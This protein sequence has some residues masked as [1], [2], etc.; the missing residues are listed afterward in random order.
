MKETTYTISEFARRTG[1]TL[2]TLRFYDEIELLVPQQY[3]NAG[4]R[5]Y[6][7]AELATLQHIQ[8]LKFIG[9]SLQEIQELLKETSPSSKSFDAS[10]AMQYKLMMEKRS[11]LDR[12]IDAI[13]RIQFLLREGHELDWSI[14]SPLLH[15]IKHEEEHKE[16]MK[17]YFSEEM[18]NQ[19]YSLSKEE[20]QT[21]DSEWLK[22]LV[23]MKTL[24]KN[25]VSPQASEAKEVLAALTELVLKYVDKDEFTRQLEQHHDEINADI[26]DFRFPNFFTEEEEEFL[27]KVGESLEEEMGKG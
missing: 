24:V 25:N 21:L 12:A 9:Y 19:L 14:I 13:E 1:L 18:V 16:W 4:H 10:L 17:E 6:G 7:L 5:L 23:K 22:L 15:S 20:R 3:N 8:T 27:Q 2:R 11:E 26:D